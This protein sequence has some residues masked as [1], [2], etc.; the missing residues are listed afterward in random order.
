MSK[1]CKEKNLI[2]DYDGAFFRNLPSQSE[3]KKVRALLLATLCP[4]Y[5]VS[6][7]FWLGLGLGLE[8]GLGLGLVV[9]DEKM[10]VQIAVRSELLLR[11][12]WRCGHRG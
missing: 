5:G 4:R 7:F 11:D 3:F 12:A 1:Y 2:G 6:A 10:A 9:V 8:L